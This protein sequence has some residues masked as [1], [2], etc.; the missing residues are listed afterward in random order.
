MAF[1]KNRTFKYLKNLFIGVGAGFIIIGALLKLIH[2]PLGNTVL[3]ASMSME[4][5]IFFLQ[6]ILP[7]DKDYYWEKLYPGLDKPKGEV[8]GAQTVGIRGTGTTAKLDKALDKAG[9]NQDLI[10][11]LGTHL[12]SLSDNMK[13]L[14]TVTNTTSATGEFTKNAQAAAKALANVKTVYDKAAV[15][16]KDFALTSEST[17]KYHEQVKSA[18]TN[19]AKLNAVYELELQDTNN[20]LKALNQFY[21]HLT[22]AI[23]NLNESVEDTKKYKKEMASLAKNLSNLNNVYGNMLSA[24]S[25]GAKGGKR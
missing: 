10:K 17:K 5:A 3:I 7:P 19:L 1:Y 8:A 24:M 6:G 11:R 16:G 4:A 21:G 20:H 22:S 9:V 18:S 12:N 15:V 13:Q 25:M 14:S 2:H 23:G